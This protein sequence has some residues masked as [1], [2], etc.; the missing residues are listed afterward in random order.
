[1]SRG[2]N[3]GPEAD[4]FALPQNVVDPQNMMASQK[5]PQSDAIADMFVVV[6][7]VFEGAG[8]DLLNEVDGDEV[9]LGVGEGYV[10]GHAAI[11][12]CCG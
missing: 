4:R 12:L 8:Q 7:G 9:A 10:T 5:L 1:M 3:S 2:K 6:Q 11:S